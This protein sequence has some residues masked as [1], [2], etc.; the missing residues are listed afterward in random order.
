MMRT[1]DVAST[2]V[3][4]REATGANDGLPADRYMRGD[5]LPWCAGFLLWCNQQS[6]DPKLYSTTAEYYLMRAV[7]EFENM[8]R[9]RQKWVAFNP[10]VLP[11]ENNIIFFRNRGASDSGPGRHVGIILTVD[12]ERERIT[13]VEG[14]LGNAVRNMTYPL[15]VLRDRV[16]GYGLI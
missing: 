13:T 14:N 2:Q 8:M 3:G 9:A 6:E 1:C 16:T 12:S 10:K 5:K 7:S 4:V 11:Q 15:S